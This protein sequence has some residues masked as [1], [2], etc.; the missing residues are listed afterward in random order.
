[1]DIAQFIGE[2]LDEKQRRAELAQ[3]AIAGD[4][5][6]WELVAQQL[7]A[8][9]DTVPMI[10]RTGQLLQ[11]DAD[12]AYVLRDVAAKRRILEMYRAVF[13]AYRDAPHAG[14][15]LDALSKIPGSLKDKS[16]HHAEVRG[17]EASLVK[18]VC[19]IAAIDSEHPD[20]NE[21]WRLAA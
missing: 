3:Q 4:W 16:T 10:G 5:D 8:C 21:A 7:H 19:A 6:S 2:R 18:V 20:F 17:A 1:M 12:P 15:S 13:G 11:A 9:C 14:L